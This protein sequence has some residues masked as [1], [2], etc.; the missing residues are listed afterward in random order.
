MWLCQGVGMTQCEAPIMIETASTLTTRVRRMLPGST[1]CEADRS[2]TVSRVPVKMSRR[3]IDRPGETAS[4]TMKLSGASSDARTRRSSRGAS[5]RPRCSRNSAAGGR[6]GHKRVE[7]LT[8]PRGFCQSNS[9][10]VVNSCSKSGFCGASS[11]GS[12][13]AQK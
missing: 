9:S 5:P 11:S 12:S 4:T 3:P 8:R 6:A 7:N 1:I 10:Q 2:S 13:L